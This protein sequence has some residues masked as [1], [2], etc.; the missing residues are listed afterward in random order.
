MPC[1]AAANSWRA[2]T[3][4]PLPPLPST[5]PSRFSVAERVARGEEGGREGEGEGV[6]VGKTTVLD[7]G[8]SLGSCV[9]S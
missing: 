5:F 7:V 2:L 4:P 6:G 1:S 8:F 3:P 9:C